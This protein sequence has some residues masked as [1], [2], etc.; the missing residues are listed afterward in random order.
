MKIYFSTWYTFVR[1]VE[2]QRRIDKRN[3]P[4]E[5][6]TIQGLQQHLL[7]VVIFMVEIMLVCYLRHSCN[8]S[9]TTQGL[10]TPPQLIVQVLSF[11]SWGCIIYHNIIHTHTHLAQAISNRTRN[12]Y[13]HT[14]I[15]THTHTYTQTHLAQAITCR[16]RN[17]HIH[18][19]THTHTYTQT[20]LAQA[21]TC[22]FRLPLAVTNGNRFAN[23]FNGPNK[24]GL[25]QRVRAASE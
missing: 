2:G 10:Q 20:H 11:K 14:Y 5:E 15:H 6:F 13:I 18:I 7:D 21:I 1:C 4:L 25:R 22:R 24:Q 17:T 12:T 9:F 3:N 16:F 8:I 19:H 23:G